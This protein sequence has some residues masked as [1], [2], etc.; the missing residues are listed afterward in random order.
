[1]KKSKKTTQTFEASDNQ[2]SF[3]YMSIG[4]T[5]DRLRTTSVTIAYVALNP[6][7]ATLKP[8]R[9]GLSYDW[10]TGR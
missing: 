8:Q 4:R 3:R 10:Y 6:L 9:N 7:I 2:L 1:M 5:T